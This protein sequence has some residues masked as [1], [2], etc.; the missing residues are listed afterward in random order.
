MYLVR[1]ELSSKLA[2]LKESG[3]SYRVGNCS[4]P[5]SVQEGIDLRSAWAFT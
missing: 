4:V 3:P 5:E 2:F 1:E